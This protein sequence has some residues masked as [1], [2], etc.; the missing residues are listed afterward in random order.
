MFG[1]RFQGVVVY[2]L[3]EPVTQRIQRRAQR[4]DVL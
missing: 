2:R 3:D 1:D 4:A